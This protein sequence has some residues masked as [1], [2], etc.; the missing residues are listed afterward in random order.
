MEE[1]RVKL[2]AATVL[3]A[4]RAMDDF[5][6][7]RHQPPTKLA[8]PRE[9][10]VVCPPMRSNINVSRIAHGRVLRRPPD[11]LLRYGE[12]AGENRPR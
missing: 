5:I 10:V 7:Q 2:S 3:R 6:Q 11:D 1:R 9:L 12:T 8:V 4:G